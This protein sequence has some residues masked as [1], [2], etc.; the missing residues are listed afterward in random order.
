[1]K[2]NRIA[3]I[4]LLLLTGISLWIVFQEKSGTISGEQKDFAVEDTASITKIHMKDK[5]GKEVTLE[6][7]G[8]RW[9]VNGKYNARPDGINLLL[10][11]VRALKVR[12]PAPKR[13][14]NTIVKDLATGAKKISIYSGDKLIKAYYMGT[15]TQDME[16]NYMLMVDPET[17]ENAD[18]P[19]VVHI[20][21]F[22]GYLSPRFFL[23][24]QEW[25]DREVFRYKY[26]D[27]KS[28]KVD[29]YNSQDSSFVIN[30]LGDN[31]FELLDAKGNRIADFDTA[32][33]RQY[34]SYY[35][36]LDY[37]GIDNI[38]ERTRDSLLLSNWV[39]TISVTDAKNAIR[40]LRCYL[41]T[42]KSPDMTD[43]Q[44]LPLKYDVDR[45]WAVV[46]GN[47]KEIVAIQYYVFGKTFVPIHRFF[48]RKHMK[49]PV[50][51]KK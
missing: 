10:S 14:Q 37:E 1:M 5:A 39:V 7:A 40:T 16:G 33:V 38:P 8:D 12:N 42:P 26:A 20:P 29:Y 23:G 15:E 50:S 51:V 49:A 13:A 18:M 46:N 34:V 19:F 43:R 3:V 2:K 27:L 28:I 35:Y 44:G 22:Q 9:I 48:K 21:G 6:R 11:T 4:V 41:K 32:E 47:E 31:T 36:R 25:R 17:G 30:S 45:M 24:E